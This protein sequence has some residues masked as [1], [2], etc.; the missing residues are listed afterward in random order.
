MNKWKQV[1]LS[2]VGKVSGGKRIP[3]G[4]SLTP[5]PNNHPY[6]SVT[7]MRGGKI[8]IT[9]LSFVPD[10]VVDS[11]KR[12]RVK[13]NDLIVSVAGTLG[14]VARIPN[15]LDGANLTEN[16]DRISD[17]KIDNDFLFQ[18]LSSNVFQSYV[19]AQATMNAQP[20]L[21]LDNL[22]SFSFA[23]PESVEQQK[24]IAKVLSTW[25]EAI[26]AVD[27]MIAK[28]ARQKN[29]F[30]EQSFSKKISKKTLGEV[31]LFIK[32]GTHGSHKDAA[33][34]KY[35]LSAKDVNNGKIYFGSDSRVISNQDFNQ[36][37]K[38]FKL[39]DGDVLLT[40]VGS[41]GRVAVLEKYDESYTFQRSVAFIR[42]K[43]DIVLPDYLATYLSSRKAQYDIEV[44]SNGLAQ[45]GIYLG[46]L[47]KL[48]IPVLPLENQK[49]VADTSKIFQEK[50]DNLKY[51]KSL[52]QKQKK[53]L[54]QQ[55]LTGKVRIT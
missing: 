29:H 15:D 20:K 5:T 17:V 44:R 51:K 11:I 27:T 19:L 1:K 14:L 25:D 2:D 24:K 55:L 39:K 6:I 9:D 33:V 46:E 36:I 41:I 32:D 3:K 45:A 53:G 35:L 18:L 34:G 16:A 52:L 40:I 7:S 23:C 42:T 10:A 26:E 28:V 22:R 37:H 49:L 43:S 50:I 21:S 8:S 31:C 4:F 38:K 47:A 13:A 30:V 48:L 12:Y 54:M